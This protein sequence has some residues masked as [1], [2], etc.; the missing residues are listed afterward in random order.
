[1]KHI[2]TT[3]GAL[4]AWTTPALAAGATDATG[5]SLITILF[6]GF[7]ALIVACQLIPGLALLCT[8][9]KGLLGLG[10]IKS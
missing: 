5:T 2:M 10:V 7:G 1:M 8:M 9:I 4:M 3:L 6:L